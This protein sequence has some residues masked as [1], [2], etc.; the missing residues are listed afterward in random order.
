MAGDYID[1]TN[2]RQ[3][4]NWMGDNSGREIRI[5]YYTV[6]D[7]KIVKGFVQFLLA[8]PASP[9]TV[10]FRALLTMEYD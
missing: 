5:A 10:S 9:R 8:D 7:E 2:A 4:F 1:V 6:A 3:K